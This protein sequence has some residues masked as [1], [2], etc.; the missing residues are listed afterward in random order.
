MRQ[1]EVPIR[2]IPEPV[3]FELR[4]RRCVIRP[5]LGGD[6][7][8]LFEAAQT[9]GF[10]DWMSWEAPTSVAAIEQRFERQLVRWRRG[11]AFCFSAVDVSCGHVVGGVDLKPDA[12]THDLGCFN[13]GYWTHPR[14][15]RRG[16]ATE[17]V[18]CV[19]GWAFGSMGTHALIAGVAKENEASHH[20][21]RR[22]GFVAF[23]RRDTCGT[24]KR[25]HNIRYRLYPS[26]L[27][28][29]ES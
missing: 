28:D 15:Q 11:Q 5:A 23:E 9:P 29:L 14:W 20:I 22:L 13:L 25:L 7:W 24:E 26:G 27:A 17:V 2:S 1:H 12:F 6:A 19:V 3:S 4:S 18:A 10:L 8:A 16:Y 21:L